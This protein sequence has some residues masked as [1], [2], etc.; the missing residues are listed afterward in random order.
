[1]RGQAGPLSSLYRPFLLCLLRFWFSSCSEALLELIDYCFRKVT[2][3]NI[4]RFNA[5]IDDSA[6]VDLLK[7]TAEQ[8][9]Q[10]IEA[11]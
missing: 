11:A 2:L 4:G 1:M 9:L 7:E 6:A 5:F 10:A 3:M 8:T